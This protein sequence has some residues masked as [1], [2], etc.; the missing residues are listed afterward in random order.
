MKKGYTIIELL[1]VISIAGILMSLGAFSWNAVAARSRDNTRK[2]DLE[3][4]KTVL[5]QYASDYRSYPGVKTT[6]GLN[7]IAQNQLTDGCLGDVKDRLAPKYMANIPADPKKDEGC[8]NLS[9]GENQKGHYLYLSA[10]VPDGLSNATGFALMATLEREADRVAESSNPLITDVT[11][12]T[13][14]INNNSVFDQNYIIYGGLN[15]TGN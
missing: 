9:A 2:T 4:I 6:Q 8:V 11:N 12:F 14:Y 13:Y 5:E 3:R 7:L 10:G 15:R 1:V